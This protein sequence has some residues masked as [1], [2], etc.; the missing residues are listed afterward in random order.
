LLASRSEL[1]DVIRADQG[2]PAGSASVEQRVTA[3]L[4]RVE[5]GF[6][7]EHAGGSSF[8]IL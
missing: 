5:A 6:P 3:Q 4:T 1:G 7:L 2:S 8:G